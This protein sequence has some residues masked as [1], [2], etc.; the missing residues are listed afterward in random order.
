MELNF[1]S[2][3]KREV[4]DILSRSVAVIDSPQDDQN[5][6]TMRTI[7]AL[8]ACRKIITTNENITAYDFYDP[9]NIYVSK[10]GSVPSGCFLRSEP[11]S[12]PDALYRKYSL[13]GFV[14][15]LMS[16]MDGR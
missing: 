4:I 3:S 9:I 1:L 13:K 2:L 8:G 10:E 7:E 12:I 11:I 16:N 6:L 14:E 5:G 15:S